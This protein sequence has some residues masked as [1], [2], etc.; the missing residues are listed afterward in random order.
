MG[1]GVGRERNAI[2]AIVSA[3]MA[4]AGIRLRQVQREGAGTSAIDCCTFAHMIR[5]NPSGGSGTASLTIVSAPVISS[6]ASR[7]SAQSSR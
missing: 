7:H 4:P 1:I 5:S 3:A 2:P 6:Q